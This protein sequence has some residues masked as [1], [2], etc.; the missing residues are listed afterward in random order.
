MSDSAAD[1]DSRL[2]SGTSVSLKDSCSF[3]LP[4]C[5]GAVGTVATEVLWKCTCPAL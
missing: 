2:I 5:W 3:S 1:E 4:Q